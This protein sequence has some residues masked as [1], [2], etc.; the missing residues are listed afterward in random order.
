MA[1]LRIL[2]WPDPRLKE[3]ADPVREVT[4]EIAQLCR[5]M[6]ETM[7]AAPGVGLAA[8]Q[9]GVKLRILVA[10]CRR[11]KHPEEEGDEEEDPRATG[12][13][14]LTL[15]NPEIVDRGGQIVCEEGC[16]SFPGELAEVSRYEWVKVRA[17]DI[18]GKPFEI[19]AVDL[20]ARCLQH[21]I[22]HLDGIVFTEKLSSLKRSLIHKRMV[23]AAREAREGEAD[24]GR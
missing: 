7:Y 20:L 17:L 15:I 4:P 5:D 8:T 13:G 2:T 24:Q 11:P 22:D 23:K 14:L 19:M 21:E 1:I 18:E 3:V 16:L 12:P 9:V 10:D 6:A